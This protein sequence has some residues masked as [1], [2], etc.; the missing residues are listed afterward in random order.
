MTSACHYPC[1]LSK[2]D[3]PWPGLTTILGHAGAA[4]RRDRRAT[5]SSIL[6]PSSLNISAMNHRD[7][8]AAAGTSPSAS[9]AP[10]D[11]T[12]LCAAGFGHFEAG[13]ALDAQL[14]C[15]QA[16]AIDPEHADTMHLVGL[17]SA[18]A[19]QHDLALEWLSRAIRQ[20]PK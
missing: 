7:R 19:A 16:L 20:A 13:R 8:Q 18:Q 10:E 17:L 9:G 5:E 4:R 2:T 12:A 3:S 1:V 14:C 6:R 11:A 15:Q